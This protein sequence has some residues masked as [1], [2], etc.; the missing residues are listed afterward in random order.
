MNFEPQARES[1]NSTGPICPHRQ[2]RA[3]AG[4]KVCATLSIIALAVLLSGCA[5]GGVVH[6]GDL[7]VMVDAQDQFDISHNRAEVTP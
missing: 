7:N 2:G 1:R 3:A 5:I 4:Q 6:L